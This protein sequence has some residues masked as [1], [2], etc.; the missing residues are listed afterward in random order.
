MEKAGENTGLFYCRPGQGQIAPSVAAAVDVDLLAV[1][2]GVRVRDEIDDGRRMTEV[3]KQGRGEPL[4]FE[5][6]AA[7]IF[8]AT[9]GFFDSF[10]PERVNEMEKKLQDFLLREGRGELDAIKQ[11]KEIREG[12]EASLKEK[13][14]RFVAANA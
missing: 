14:E 6:E 7:V 1:G 10:P 3:L 12:T 9:N 13:L 8:A 11:S 2:I 5:M 4:P